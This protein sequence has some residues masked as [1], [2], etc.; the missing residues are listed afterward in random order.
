MLHDVHAGLISDHPSDFLNMADIIRNFLIF[1][2][3]FLPGKLSLNN[4]NFVSSLHWCNYCM[5]GSSPTLFPVGRV[6]I[7]PGE[8]R[9]FMCHVSTAMATT[10]SQIDWLIQ[11]E[12]SYRDLSDVQQTYISEDH[13]GDVVT[14]NR[15]EYTFTFNLTSKS[16]LSFV[17]TL[18][19][20]LNAHDQTSFGTATVD[21]NQANESATL[22]II[23]GMSTKSHQNENCDTLA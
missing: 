20:T 10:S 9:I 16:T 4:I 19:V 2:L 6:N 13:L 8:T 12:A 21:C 15:E 23:T 18:V 5:I 17:S 14:D 3:V 7:C 11:F 22:Y 1:M